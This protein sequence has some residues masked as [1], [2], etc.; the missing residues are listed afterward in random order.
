MS[1]MKS[2]S[3]IE[4]KDFFQRADGTDE[5]PGE[6]PYTRGRR[7][8]TSGTW[9]QRELSGEG[10]PSRSN[11]QFR[12]LI[13][14]GSNGLDVIGDAA[15]VAG[16]DP[17]HPIAQIS[18]GTQGVALCRKQDVVELFKNIPLD[19][20]SISCSLNPLSTVACVA[21][22]AKEYGFPLE[23]LR[24][25]IIQ[26]PLYAESCCYATNLPT[27]YRIKMT[28]DT[29]EYA[30]KHMPKYHSYIEDTYFFSESGIDGVEEMALGFLQIR[31][32]T[33][34]LIERGLDIDSFAPRIAILVN[35][36]MD[37]FEEI[38]KIRATRR[39]FANMMRDEF[40]AKDPRSHGVVVTSH[41]SGLSLTAQQPVNNIIR[42]SIQAMA[43]ALGGVQAMEVS[44]FDEAFRTPSPESHMIGLRT[45]QIVALE[46]KAAQVA[47]P[48]GGSHYVEYLTDQMEERIVNRVHQLEAMG[49]A[50]ELEK[51]GVFEQ[52][53]QD[54]M[55]KQ[56]RDVSKG[57]EPLVGVNCHTIPEE[58]D[59][60]LRDVAERKITPYHAFVEEIVE[61]KKARDM[62]K[63]RDSL[64]R[65]AET[66]EEDQNVVE[67][68]QNCLN[69]GVTFGELKGTA[70]Q[71]FGLEYDS[72][73]MVEPI[74]EKVA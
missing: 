53:F 74:L 24:G 30:T 66:I 5:K 16:I 15:T 9:I 32:L 51:R 45:Q 29:I 52:I 31:F 57:H 11:E 17:D 28:L 47:D 41:T 2:R 55:A 63:V 6:F 38:A 8:K 42:G 25:S 14:H 59:T 72:Y 44:A 58:E 34:K 56:Q 73:G 43:L 37:F 36:S 49:D 26:A 48:L 39:I 18:C 67:A 3:G 20:V 71:V 4:L 46:S 54:A 40:G 64:K 61:W 7:A 60:L 10:P 33:R 19:Q 35:C 22:A 50:D 12:Y 69:E 23:K 65:F 1:Q 70:R 68:T 62:D 27:D 21:L 13:E